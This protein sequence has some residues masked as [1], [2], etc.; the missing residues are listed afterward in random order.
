[1]AKSIWK[2]VQFRCCSTYQNGKFSNANFLTLSQ[3]CWA[4]ISN[5]KL[6]Q[7]LLLSTY[8][9]MAKARYIEV[10]HS[11]PT[12]LILNHPS[13]FWTIQVNSQ[14]SKSKSKK[15]HHKIPTIETCK[16]FK[17]LDFD[18]FNCCSRK[19]PYF[20][21]IECK[22]YLLSPVIWI[23]SI[24]HEFLASRDTFRWWH[25]CSVFYWIFFSTCRL[26]KVS[27]KK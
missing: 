15:S 14:P 1:M 12:E 2:L 10:K 22:L 3:V 11:Q 8:L 18:G 7:F 26:K 23:S 6:F 21:L 17:C 4:I 24:V 5:R 20:M 13:W 27:T 16:S 9:F 25:T 19:I